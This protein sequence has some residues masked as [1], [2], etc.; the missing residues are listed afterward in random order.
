MLGR[1][2]TLAADAQLPSPNSNPHVTQGQQ[3][4][5]SSQGPR[6]LT[7]SSE[8]RHG[9]NL[10]LAAK[11]LR[12]P[13]FP[14]GQ[15][16]PTYPPPP[17]GPSVGAV[18]GGPFAPREAG[19]NVSQQMGQGGHQSG[20]H[21]PQSSQHMNQ[22]NLSS[23][24]RALVGG[25]FGSEPSYPMSLATGYDANNGFE[26]HTPPS[27]ETSPNMG[28]GVDG[29]GIGGVDGMNVGGLGMNVHGS[30]GKG[31]PMLFAGVGV[32]GEP[33]DMNAMSPDSLAMAMIGQEYGMPG[34]FSFP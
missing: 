19:E 27:F 32:E 2:L 26:T 22:A 5:N 33:F 11:S 9:V 3:Q 4:Q 29:M 8:G 28:G 13:T 12:S 6:G 20:Q 14:P 17:P 31:S 30:S 24:Q 34:G 21:M 18:G 23:A 7:I 25:G 15:V 1:S 16:D 10:A